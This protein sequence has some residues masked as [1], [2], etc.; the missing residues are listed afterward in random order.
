MIIRLNSFWCI[1][2]AYFTTE[3]NT[4]NSQYWIILHFQ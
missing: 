3:L 4:M 2:V 1:H